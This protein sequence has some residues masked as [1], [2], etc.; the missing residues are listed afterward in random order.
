MVSDC[1]HWGMA[2][3]LRLDAEQDCV[4]SELAA[5]QGLSK[6]EAAVRAIIE[7][8]ER[9]LHR[10]RVAELAEAAAIRYEDVLDRLG[11]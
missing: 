3:T 11:E 10:S 6:Q 8:A 4:L 7:T 1:Y 9:H 5:S 2:M